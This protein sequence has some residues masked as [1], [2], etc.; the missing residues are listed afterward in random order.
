MGS[1]ETD[2]VIVRGRPWDRWN[3]TGSAVGL[4]VERQED[5]DKLLAD[6]AS[7]AEDAHKMAIVAGEAVHQLEEA[8]TALPPCHRTLLFRFA[9]LSFTLLFSAESY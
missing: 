6:T 9:S 5:E 2:G 7:A 8:S 1:W 4:S 3:M